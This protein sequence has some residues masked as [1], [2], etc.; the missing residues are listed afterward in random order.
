M[1]L[2]GG[3]QP[4]RGQISPEDLTEPQQTPVDRGAT[5]HGTKGLLRLGKTSIFEGDHPKFFM[6]TSWNMMEY[7]GDHPYMKVII[8][9]LHHSGI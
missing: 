9:K 6:E 7:E 4:V 1:N 5:I 3:F 2:L 8:W